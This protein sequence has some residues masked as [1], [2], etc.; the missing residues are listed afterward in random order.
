MTIPSVAEHRDSGRR[1]LSP[2]HPHPRRHPSRPRTLLDHFVL[3][4]SVLNLAGVLLLVALVG[5]VSEQWWLSLALSY[6]PRIPWVVP[7]ML[8]VLASLLLRRRM[9]WLN[10]F[11]MLL[12]LGPVMGFRI[13]LS[14][15]VGGA[16]GK[17]LT[18]VSD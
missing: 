11:S 10:L 9:V 7:S 3:G 4:L 8:L 17:P 5:I 15:W 13:P 18:V 12:V 6:L 2:D 14:T 16:N 1:L